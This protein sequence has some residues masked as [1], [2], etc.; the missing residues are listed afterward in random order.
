MVPGYR[1]SDLNGESKVLT[2]GARTVFINRLK[3]VKVAECPAQRGRAPVPASIRSSSP[4]SPKRPWVQ[5]RPPPMVRRSGS[6]S[7]PSSARHFLRKNGQ[8]VRQIG[9][10][11][12][13]LQSGFDI[14]LHCPSPAVEGPSTKLVHQVFP[15]RGSRDCYENGLSGLSAAADVA[16]E[17]DGIGEDFLPKI[18]A[19]QDPPSGL[20]GLLK[21][22]LELLDPLV[23][24]GKRLL[25]GRYFP[26]MDLVPVLSPGK[27]IG[28]RVGHLQGYQSAA[29]VDKKHGGA[30][31]H[32]LDSRAAGGSSPCFISTSITG[33][34]DPDPSRR[35]RFAGAT[36]STSS[37]SFS[38]PR[39]VVRAS[40]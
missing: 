7:T 20:F 34:M 21:L 9:L 11:H 10:V 39:L 30:A 31:A 15:D 25:E 38:F 19:L 28:D 40:P 14:V 1:S 29:E 8:D 36:S 27:E 17:Q 13:H 16:G 24:L 35:E 4:L 3:A 5:Y 2:P 23:P 37:V 6:S 33:V 26:T 18:R 32:I 22:A 12:R